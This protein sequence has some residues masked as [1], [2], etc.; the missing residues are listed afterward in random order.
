MYGSPKPDVN[1][2]RDSQIALT[3]CFNLLKEIDPGTTPNYKT[4][5]AQSESYTGLLV[6]GQS[7]N[8]ILFY[9]RTSKPLGVRVKVAG[10]ERGN[11]WRRRLQQ[12]GGLE[13]RISDKKLQKD[14]EEEL[15]KIRFSLPKEQ[16][17]ADRNLLRELFC[18]S[19]DTNVK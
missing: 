2:S 16:F 17:D 4:R 13:I 8:F 7:K 1:E 11:E 9:P 14:R 18:E 15:R 6:N 5:K 3:K 10:A 12:A 19:Y